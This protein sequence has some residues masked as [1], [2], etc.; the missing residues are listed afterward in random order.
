[1]L[2]DKNSTS[3]AAS[4]ESWSVRQASSLEEIS[5]PCPFISVPSTDCSFTL[6]LVCPLCSITNL[7][8]IPRSL[9][10]LMASC[11]VKPAINPRAV[12]P[13]PR[14]FKTVDTL[15][16]LPPAVRHS[17]AVR[18]VYPSLKFSTDTI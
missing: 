18:F 15:I 6:I 2:P 14:F 3:P 1:M 11:P 13:M 4:F 16:P 12:F 5:G 8:S 17:Y 10:C 9:S 7:L